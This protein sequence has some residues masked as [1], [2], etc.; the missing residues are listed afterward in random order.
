MRGHR[1]HSGVKNGMPFQISIKPVG[2]APAADQPTE[3]AAREDAV[4]TRLA[5]DLVALACRDRL[6]ARS[7]R[8][9]HGD[10]DAGAGPGRG[11]AM[12][13]ELGS[14]RFGVLEVPPGEHLHAVQADLERPG[15]DPV[16]PGRGEPVVAEV[17]LGVEARRARAGRDSP[18]AASG[19]PLGELPAEDALIGPNC[20]DPP[21]M[22]DLGHP[23]P[24]Q[25]DDS[26]T[27]HRARP[28]ARVG[29]WNAPSQATL[30]TGSAGSH[31]HI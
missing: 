26:P 15:D 1:A 13:V 2:P 29:T 30:W 7:G 6:L 9:A 25:A 10:V 4:T 20:Q 21:Q 14:S 8:G 16:E 12:G 23:I 3:R 19:L 11:H 31:R 22:I 28:R 17:A 5:D 27:T 24:P 18:I